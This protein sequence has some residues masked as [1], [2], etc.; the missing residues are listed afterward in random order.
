MNALFGGIPLFDPTGMMNLILRF[1]LNVVATLVLI[2]LL[3]YRRGGRKDYFFTDMV[4]SVTVFLLCFLLES[5]KIQLGFALGLFAVFG[6]IRYRT[7]SIP[8]KEMTYLF[9][10]IGLSVVNALANKK[11]SYA[12]LV[13][14]NA[15]LLGTAAVLEYGFLGRAERSEKVRYDRMDLIVPEKRAEMIADLRARLG[16]DVVRVE[17]GEIDFLHDIAIVTVFYRPRNSA[18]GSGK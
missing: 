7:E 14:T 9:A 3:Y 15:A 5:V 1:A 2:G 16:F 13:F 11:V 18:K 17:V 4:I 10:A 8:I 6:I 12:E